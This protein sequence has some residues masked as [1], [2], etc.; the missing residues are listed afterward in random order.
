MAAVEAVCDSEHSP[1]P[2]D[3]S[4]AARVEGTKPSVTPSIRHCLRVIAGDQRRHKTVVFTEC[5]NVELQDHIT[6]VF[7]MLAGSGSRPAYVVQTRGNFKKETL[8]ITILMQGG[9][10]VEKGKREPRN[11]FTVRRI[12]VTGMHFFSYK[13]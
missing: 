4:A 1:E 11:R 12:L 6:G 10:S 13:R 7:M 8:A 5:R 9:K 2:F 3:Q